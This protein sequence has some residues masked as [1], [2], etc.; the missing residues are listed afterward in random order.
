MYNQTGVTAFN[1]S[2]AGMGYNFGK[3]M[4]RLKPEPA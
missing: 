2:G 3:I 1:L 4:N